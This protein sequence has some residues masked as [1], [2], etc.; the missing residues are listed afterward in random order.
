MGFSMVVR[1]AGN[2][3]LTRLLLP[4]VFGV[5]AMVNV[6][7]TGLQ[8]FSDIGVGPSI[9]QNPRGD[10]TSF[11]NTAWTI[12]VFRGLVLTILAGLIGWPLSIFY[13]Q[14][15]FLY[16][17]PVAG[18]TALVAGFKSTKIFNANRHLLLGRT[19]MMNLSAQVGGVLVMVG[20][21]LVWPSIWA[22]VIGGIFN[23]MFVMLIS[24]FI[25]PGEINRFHWER[26]A[27]VSLIRY[28]RWIFLGTILTFLAGQLDRLI[29]AKLITWDEMGV[30]SVA[31][32]LTDQPRQLL[33][34]LGGAVVFPAISRRADIPRNELRRKISHNRRL[35][36]I[37]MAI[38]VSVLASLGDQVVL[39]L[40][41]EQFAGASWMTTILAIG[42]WPTVLFI[43]IGPGLMSIGKPQYD[44]AAKFV[45]LVWIGLMMIMA[46]NVYGLVG[47]VV[48]TALADIPVY[49]LVLA[50]LR[51]ERLSCFMQDVWSSVLFVSITA[52]ILLIRVWSGLGMPEAYEI[53]RSSVMTS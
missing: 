18:L 50:G 12:Q 29:G 11:L 4:E 28:G 49:L 33:R 20:I 34:R 21:A 1:L 36:L 9:I 17:L 43:T 10:D 26:A 37:L 47:F 23:V 5:M 52:V 39:L 8:M 31:F 41:P 45:R 22:L 27:A 2:L 32:M 38:G 51:R 16:L 19:T 7:M 46:F 30:Y 48:V 25:L 14:D 44:A 15:Q 35:V 53:I 6:F 40:W 42:L 3:A 24:H 13:D